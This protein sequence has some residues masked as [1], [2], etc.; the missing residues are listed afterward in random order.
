MTQ[1][2]KLRIANHLLSF[3]VADFLHLCTPR[4]ELANCRGVRCSALEYPEACRMGREPYAIEVSADKILLT[5][6]KRCVRMAVLFTW[7]AAFE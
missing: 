7:I 2:T 4:K 3:V 1:I 6:A 5:Q